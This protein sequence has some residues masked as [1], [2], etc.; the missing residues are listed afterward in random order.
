MKEVTPDS[1]ILKSSVFHRLL[2]RAFPEWFPYDSIHFFHPFYTAEQN[3]IF[4]KDQG[5]AADFRL[6]DHLK[7]SEPRKPWKPIYLSTESTIKTVLDDKDDSFVH[8]ARFERRNLPRKIAEV[9]EP[10]KTSYVAPAVE[11]I[12]GDPVT[13]VRYFVNLMRD[14]IKR[15]IV[16][17]DSERPIYQIDITREY[18]CHPCTNVSAS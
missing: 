10:G 2:Q 8:P 6:D 4:A 5:Y 9:L 18:A 16:T 13:T 14:I 1:N 17:V 3:A 11:G 15:E 7:A 12:D